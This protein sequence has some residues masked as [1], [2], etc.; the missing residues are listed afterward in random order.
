L[1]GHRGVAALYRGQPAEC[2]SRYEDAW[3]TLAALGEGPVATTWW[4]ALACAQAYTG[5]PRAEE[6]G[7]QVIAAFEASGERWGRALV[8]LALGHRAWFGGDREAA[9]ALTRSALENMR[10]FHD[11][12]MV[13]RM[14][15]LLAWTT[16]A[17]GGHDRAA[18]LLGAAD[19]LWRNAG[20]SIAAFVP[21]MADQHARCEKSASI[22]LGLAAYAQA[23]S[24]GSRHD[25]PVQA[26]AYAL[27]PG[28]GPVTP[29]ARTGPLTPRECDVAELIARGLGNRQI[30]TALGRSPRTID[31]H[32][33]NILAKL[34]YSS[35]ARLAAWWT[36]NHAS[37]PRTSR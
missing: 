26:I 14:L 19:A 16:S 30:A 24:E 22:A 28:P 37:S 4:L 21:D 31:R 29:P 17:G 7:R 18:R 11:H 6:T 3:T 10:G 34:G 36:N 8:L 33:E 2:V 9:K 1:T 35:R 13:A 25:S 23:F 27:D 32:V 20:S 15:E 12:V 5:D